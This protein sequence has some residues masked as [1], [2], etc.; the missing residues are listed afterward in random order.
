[1]TLRVALMRPLADAERSAA[2]LRARGFETVVAPVLEIH[3]T[4]AEPPDE[5]FDA[6]LATSA[7]AFCFLS[8]E[9]RTRLQGMALHVV[10]ER[11]AAAARAIGLSPAG[12]ICADA[13]GL[14]DSL[15]GRLPRPARLLYL[16]GRERKD[17]LERTLRAAGH[18]VVAVEVYVAAA[19]AWNATEA[20]AV[21]ACG[22]ALH[23]SRRS[24]ELTIA[25]CQRA[26][27]GDHLMATLHGCISADAAAPLRSI[28]ARRIVVASGAHESL[29][30]DAL[31]SAA[32]NPRGSDQ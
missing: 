7:N 29:L 1:L 22:A 2:L 12:G 9:A 30:I 8:P 18:E 13:A 28:G 19:R 10:G 21:A 32:K 20:A 24:A 26:G 23:Y 3:A 31:S 16:A 5:A 4:G 15:V 25:L 17:D 14:A 27:L 11:T 6:A